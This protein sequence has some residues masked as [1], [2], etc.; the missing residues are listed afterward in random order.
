MLKTLS[1]L[2][3]SDTIVDPIV[4][5]LKEE[6]A[7]LSVDAITAPY[8]QVNQIL[9][10][11][12]HPVWSNTPDVA[13][14]WT[15]PERISPSFDS[16]LQ[17][18]PADRKQIMNDVD[19]FAAMVIEASK[20]SKFTFVV[21]WSLPPHYR[22]VQTLA[23]KHNIGI[24]NVVMQMNLRLAEH[25]VN[26][27]HIVMLDSQYWYT[28][29]QKQSYDAKM[30]AL[31]KIQYSRDFFVVAAK[32]IKA[33]LPG[34]IGQAKKLIVC[35]LD[36]T[37]WG[38]VIGDDG[39][40]GIKLGGID[41]IGES[42]VAFQKGLKALKN[43]GILLAICSKNEEPIAFE[44]IE[45]HPEM[46]LK[47]EDFVAWRI[48]W[49]DKAENIIGIANEL[50][51]GLQSIV[52]LDD[53]PTERERIRQALPEV[54][55]PE[56]PKDFVQYPVFI[57]TLDCFETIDITYED[58]ERTTMYHQETAR[59]FNLST[60]SSIVEWLQSL[61]L[62]VTVLQLNRNNLARAVQLLNKT[63]QFNLATRRVSQEEFW[64]WSQN[65][66]NHVYLFHVQDRFGEQ[67][68]TGLVSAIVYEMTEID[69]IDEIDTK[70]VCVKEAEMID[71]VMSC[72]VMGKGVEDAM[73]QFVYRHLS[74]AGVQ[75]V[76]AIY[77]ETKKNKPF[78]DFIQNK[79]KNQRSG[80][81]ENTTDFILD[82]N[83][84]G[85]P[86]HITC[87]DNTN[88]EQIDELFS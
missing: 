17:F 75:R 43:R 44:M 20:R 57:Q 41:P 79:Y 71:F 48:N 15:I 84:A 61:E 36:N 13:V 9:M 72:R 62:Q 39:M 66:N 33:I 5:F 10:D 21:S 24:T 67:G 77:R 87:I 58:L 3:I 56:L 40:E 2:I 32:E 12:S 81:M 38:G 14:I 25:F 26:Y 49:K 34:V 70:A 47:K 69:E 63:N 46:V 19:Q 73:L 74:D 37:L 1:A 82:M 64:L 50:N 6:T 30:Y 42:F 86:S 85:F 68:I 7:S 29:L 51:L 8:N 83:L 88:K 78:F 22:W 80:K 65:P 28:A 54:Y 55:T 16:L 18:E 45:T 31:G 59:K 60:A 35:D 11:H 27:P 52:F 53:N 4:R 76:K 23:W